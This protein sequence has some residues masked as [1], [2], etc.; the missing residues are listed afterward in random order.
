MTELILR[1]N[2]PGDRTG[3]CPYPSSGYN[4]DKV[5][6]VVVD[7]NTTYVS[8]SISHGTDYD[9]YNL[10]NRDPLKEAGT[11][12]SVRVYIT[13]YGGTTP[14]HAYELIKI[15]GNIYQNTEDMI[16]GWK[17]FAYT[18]TENP[19]T[20]L[21]WTWDDIDNLQIGV[22][23]EPPTGGIMG[24]GT[25]GCT[26]VAVKI[27]Y[28]SVPFVSNIAP[29]LVEE[30]T[31]TGNANIT[32]VGYENA[33]KRGFCYNTTGSPTVADDKVEEEGDYGTG[34]YDLAI[35]LLDPGTLKTNGTES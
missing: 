31:A 24:Q 7:Y 1:P 3:L 17:S 25:S 19:A 14:N 9:L 33:T 13:V 35:T 23:L 32:D 26:Q 12:N 16:Q 18:W 20:S 4:W 15:G 8:T 22:K 6:D 30:T 11:I 2:A 28:D 27:T 5:D 21:A 10:R 29:T 34:L